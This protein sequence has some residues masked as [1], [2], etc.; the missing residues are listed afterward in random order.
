MA[1]ATPWNFSLTLSGSQATELAKFL[2]ACRSSVPASSDLS[3]GDPEVELL[4]A[5]DALSSSLRNQGFAF[6]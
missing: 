4:G 3:S 6:D 2:Y 1:S 5:F